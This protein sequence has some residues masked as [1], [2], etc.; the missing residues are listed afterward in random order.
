MKVGDMDGLRVEG[1][2]IIGS[3][4]IL[5]TPIKCNPP[6]WVKTPLITRQNKQQTRKTRQRA[7]VRVAD[8]PLRR[9]RRLDHPFSC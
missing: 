7:G 5:Q 1:M 6:N 3:K 8:A 2:M 4:M 9:R